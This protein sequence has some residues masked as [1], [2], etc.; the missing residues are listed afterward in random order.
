MSNIEKISGCDVYRGYAHLCDLS[1]LIDDSTEMDYNQYGAIPT[2]IRVVFGDLYK[3]I[4]ENPSRALAYIV[5]DLIEM[6]NNVD[7]NIAFIRWVS[8]E[9]EKLRRSPPNN[10]GQVIMLPYGDY[11]GGDFIIDGRRIAM[12]EGDVLIM[13]ATDT[14]GKLGPKYK[15]SPVIE[16]T[17]YILSVHCID[18][19]GLVNGGKLDDR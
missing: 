4:F 3:N 19:G 10:V 12:C 9:G 5:H 8:E 14:T 11:E 18:D 2:A 15:I 6:G 7:F 13:P 17:M 16:G 1:N